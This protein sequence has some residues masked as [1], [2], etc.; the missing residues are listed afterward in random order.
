MR[1]EDPVELE[2]VANADSSDLGGLETVTAVEDRG[3]VA[4]FALVV[5]EADPAALASPDVVDV[6]GEADDK[7]VPKQA[8]RDDGLEFAVLVDDNALVFCC[9]SS[10]FEFLKSPAD[11]PVLPSKRASH[12]INDVVAY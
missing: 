8:R 7:K 12:S 2:R 9:R 11:P 3:E 4:P 5:A 10:S 6:E 1:I